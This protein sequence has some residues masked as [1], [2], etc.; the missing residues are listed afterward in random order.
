[1]GKRGGDFWGDGER[2][3]GAIFTWKINKSEI[4]NDKKNTYTNMFFSLQRI[5][6]G[7]F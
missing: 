4:F 3:G 7:K 5:E 2:G 6:T 1:M